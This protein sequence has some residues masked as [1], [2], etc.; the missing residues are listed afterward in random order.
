M[1]RHFV[2][3]RETPTLILGANFGGSSIIRLE[4]ASQLRPR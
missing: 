1:L 4:N 2:E 3:R